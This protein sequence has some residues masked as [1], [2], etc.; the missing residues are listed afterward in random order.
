MHGICSIP[1]RC[2]SFHSRLQHSFSTMSLKLPCRTPK[3]GLLIRLFLRG[4][5]CPICPIPWQGS[6]FQ[7]AKAIKH[8]GNVAYSL[9]NWY[10]MC[11][12][13][14]LYEKQDT[15]HFLLSECTCP[16]KQ[17]WKFL[18]LSLIFVLFMRFMWKWIGWQERQYS[19][20]YYKVC[21]GEEHWNW[22]QL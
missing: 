10:H 12:T 1:H 6:F 8:F 15:G 13:S 16:L 18:S 22:Y 4:S 19:I 5:P 7:E 20:K 3:Q 2:N 21:S 14:R 17:Y 9:T 11:N